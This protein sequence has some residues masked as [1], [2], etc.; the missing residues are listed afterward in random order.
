MFP[1][2]FLTPEELFLQMMYNFPSR[3]KVRGKLASQW[4]AFFLGIA[5]SHSS[6]DDLS[7]LSLRLQ[8][9]KLSR[10]HKDSIKNS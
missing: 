9:G 4:Q 2:G 10:A 8:A 7:V 6:T 5:S 1:L 3:S